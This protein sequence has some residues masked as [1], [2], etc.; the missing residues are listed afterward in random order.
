[1]K[2]R[3]QNRAHVQ[4]EAQI[5]RLNEVF[6]PSVQVPLSIFR[7]P[8]AGSLQQQRQLLLVGRP[9]RLLGLNVFHIGI[10][11]QPLFFYLLGSG[12][13]ALRQLCSKVALTGTQH[14]QLQERRR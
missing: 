10:K 14:L 7:K 11:L 9:A 4:G 13:P 1:M 5:T 6:Y 2:K 12:R 8:A 3:R